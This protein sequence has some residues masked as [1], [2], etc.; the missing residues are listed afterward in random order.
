MAQ[1]HHIV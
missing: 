1:G